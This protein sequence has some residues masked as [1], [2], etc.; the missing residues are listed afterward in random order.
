MRQSV[1][2]A[3]KDVGHIQLKLRKEVYRNFRRICVDKDTNMR[4]KAA[5]L[6][7][8]FIKQETEGPSLLEMTREQKEDRAGRATRAAIAKSHAKGHPTAHADEK[9]I[10]NLYPDGSKEYVKLYSAP[11]NPVG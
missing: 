4:A 10:Y 11:E 7:E 8:E 6:I 9:G 3:E 5:Q 2:A 1:A